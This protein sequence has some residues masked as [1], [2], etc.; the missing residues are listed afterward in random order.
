MCFLRRMRYHLQLINF[1]LFIEYVL[2]FHNVQF[3]YLHDAR[4]LDF[5]T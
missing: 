1:L 2:Y 5:K 3:L 4:F